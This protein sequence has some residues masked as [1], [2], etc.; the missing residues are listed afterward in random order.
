MPACAIGMSENYAVSLILHTVR[1]AQLGDHTA[2]F[3]RF[4]AGL[5]AVISMTKE[6]SGGILGNDNGTKSITNHLHPIP[7][8]SHPASP[9]RMSK[10]ERRIR[11]SL[12]RKFDELF[13]S[14]TPATS[15]SAL[16]TS[17]LATQSN[18]AWTGLRT[19]LQSL[20]K[21]AVIFPPLQ[22]AIISVI[23][24]IDVV[25]MALE[26]PNDYE[27]LALR[28]ETLGES[29]IW[30]L[31]GSK[32]APMSEFIERTAMIIEGEANLI[33]GERDRGSGRYSIEAN[34]HI[35]E[36][37]RF[38]HRIEALFRQLQAD[39]SLST[40]NI[41]GQNLENSQLEGMT[42]AKLASYDS[43]LS[44]DVNRRT[45]TKGTRV[46][47][48]L[49]L[50]SWS[51][52]L[53]APNIYWMSGTAGAGK[54][55]LAYTFCKK[56]KQQKQLGATFF[57]TR[58]IA[59]CRDVGRIIPTIAY[60][61]ARYSLAFRLALCRI[62]GNGPNISTS[63]MSAQYERL[64]RDPILEVR[65]AIPENLI[66]VIDGLDECTDSNGVESILDILL[67]LSTDL[68][69]KFFVTTRSELAIQQMMES[70]SF[71]ARS[72]FVLHEIE[73]SLVQAD[74]ELYLAE[75]L[76]FMSPSEAQVQKLAE[77]SG[78]LFI[79]AA[80]AVRYIRAGG[81]F[82]TASGRSSPILE[83]SSQSSQKHADIDELYTIIL[84]AA[85]EDEKLDD[86]E[87]DLIRLV[88]WTTI[89]VREPVSVKTLAALGGVG[90]PSLALSA[91]R[92]LQSVLYVSRSGSTVT[93]FHASFPGF[94][95]D[96]FRSSRFFCDEVKH[97]QF[98]ARRC[99][100]LMKEQLRF[101]ICNLE[102]SF[103]RD[104]DVK[105]L[106]DRIEKY[107]SPVLSYA[108]R[109]WS[110]HLQ[111]AAVSEELFSHIGEFLSEQLLFWMEVMNLK[112]W[113]KVG[114]KMLRMSKLWLMAS[115]LML[116][117]FAERL[118]VIEQA[119]SAPLNLV[120]HIEDSRRFVA[121]FTE[122]PVSEST[123]HIYISSLPFCYRSS[124]VVRNSWR[125]TRGLAVALG[126][127][128]EQRPTIWNTPRA[129]NSVTF[130][131]DGTRIAFGTDEGIITV[132]DADNGS[133]V[134]GPLKGHEQWVLSVAF[135][136]NGIYI[137]SGSSDSTILVWSANDGTCVAGPFRGHTDAVKSV[138]FSPDSTRIV[139]G[140]WDHSVRVWG[141]QDATFSLDPFL[142][143]TKAINSVAVSPD[144][145]RIISGSD[146][147]TVYIWDAHQGTC[148]ISPLAGHSGSV[149]SVAFSPD[150]TYIISGS[151]DCTILI[152]DAF[153]GTCVA[154]P[155]EGHSGPVQSVA[156]SPDG[157]RIISGSDDT[158]IRYWSSV[159]G[160]PVTKPLKRHTKRV[161][162]VVF[163]PDG[164][165]IVSCSDDCTIHIWNT[166]SG[167]VAGH[168]DKV[169][170]AAFSPDGT[171][172]I[173]GSADRSI[174]IWGANDGS[175]VVG[176]LVG[177]TD[178]VT[179]VAISPNGT[180]IASGSEDSTIIVW[181]AL[182]G[183][184]IAG[185]LEGHTKPVTS[186]CFSPDGSHLVSGSFD[187]SLRV[188][189]THN[190][191]P[192]GDP[193]E[194][195]TDTVFSVA[196][197][198]SGAYI[199]SGSFDYTIIIWNASDG[200][201]FTAPLKGHTYFVLAVA[202]SPDG[203]RIVS[204]SVDATIRVWSALNGTLIAGPFKV[205]TDW[206]MSVA[207]SPD[208]TRIVSGS[209]DRT[210]VVS[211]A[212]NGTIV[213]GPFNGHTSWV[214][215]VAFSPNGMRIV[216]CSF[217]CTI[218][219]WD[220]HDNTSSANPPEHAS[221][222]TD[223]QKRPPIATQIVVNNNGWIMN[224]NLDLLFWVPPEVAQ[225]LPVPRNPFVI[226]RQGP[227][228][229]NYEGLFLGSDWHRCYC[230]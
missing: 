137:A 12:V 80:T 218:R 183:S 43:R 154:G 30:H 173:S 50:D 172:I 107:I 190:Y 149:T 155:L 168:T 209:D 69:L 167:P 210:V 132:K 153:D 102:S 170:S 39:A 226:G 15:R 205:H 8:L 66:V 44:A 55:T 203:T 169:S 144:G 49:E 224:Q 29:L 89:C 225:C 119:C 124:S 208:G 127:V 220:L 56:L 79:Y 185:P 60:Q 121:S 195:H 176:P 2:C 81:G 68:P 103:V 110:D 198:P 146:D 227:L 47:V 145:T 217:D 5:A 181:D 228:Q 46:D 191:T 100:E 82:A 96:Q 199:A 171:R 196:F 40:W 120:S 27:D 108:C 178:I 6:E 85:L 97:N 42:P 1:D 159:D 88:L 91:L 53:N 76:E 193:F 216:S 104:K 189:S 93:T 143:H 139:S 18:L 57:C 135:S 219:V 31:R 23:R 192:I 141:V 163:S 94:M 130:S 166:T 111:Q 202:F 118:M 160:T 64:L 126:E 65:D 157:A 41:D 125:R 129:A 201:Q 105:D 207:Y 136:P 16:S 147:H 150:G 19:R 26:H 156:F 75:E 162:C 22:S 138:A 14:S 87:K 78:N 73:R 52:D 101:N 13:R 33:N 9:V 35:E 133:L 95:F 92:P 20:H 7:P 123:P 67:R 59:E 36:L 148:I 161:W 152:W 83:A 74:I 98:L 184:R 230:T 204:S 3:G 128:I 62:L 177:H 25:E 99:F 206:I 61:L 117:I 10:H 109:Y 175:L 200:T 229:I 72:V 142:G 151:K 158:T 113:M 90:D 131:P 186:V 116:D 51:C 54:T 182:D 4:N 32:S 84:A 71:E 86:E 140:S 165:R 115:T 17:D 179:S 106:D 134:V 11:D 211:D 114:M 194:G 197:S 187:R 77:L 214:Q 21:Y 58:T 45:C 215:S 122:N 164:T 174:C 212:S 34:N 24:S 48:L 223:N 37:V 180:R 63:T 188:W 221:S 70:K 222:S 28:L 38:Y 213:A 112:H